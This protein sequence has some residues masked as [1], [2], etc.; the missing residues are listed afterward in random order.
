VWDQD[1]Q[2][3]QELINSGYQEPRRGWI[4]IYQAGRDERNVW[5]QARPEIGLILLGATSHINTTQAIKEA[6]IMKKVAK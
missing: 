2:N 1:V 4:F 3:R 5:R 6:E